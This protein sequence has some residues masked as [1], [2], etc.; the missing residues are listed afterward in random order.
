MSLASIV[1]YIIYQ[2]IVEHRYCKYTDVHGTTNFYLDSSLIT[3]SVREKWPPDY[4]DNPKYN[5]DYG[6]GWKLE[7]IT[8]RKLA[9]PEMID[10]SH[11]SML[12]IPTMYIEFRFNRTCS[13]QI[14]PLCTVRQTS[15]TKAFVYE[16][17]D[18]SVQLSNTAYSGSEKYVNLPVDVY[19]K[20]EKVWHP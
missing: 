12:L 9:V 20:G 19:V 11:S 5:Y 14:P 10:L 6:G 2:L 4:C 16:P 1:A 7:N 18:V 3:D 15:A 17:Q 8:C 13:R